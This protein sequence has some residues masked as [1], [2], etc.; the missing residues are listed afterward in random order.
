MRGT[1][2]QCIVA[3]SVVQGDEVT[4]ALGLPG[5]I[6]TKVMSDCLAP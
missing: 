6:L 3:K 2:G 4:H 5:A 1:G